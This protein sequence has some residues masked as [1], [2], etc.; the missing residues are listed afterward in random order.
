ML[1]GVADSA[2]V[3][4]ESARSGGE[5]AGGVLGV[6]QLRIPRLMQGGG[7]VFGAFGEHG[8]AAGGGL[9][10]P[11][12]RGAGGVA[13][14]LERG[15]DLLAVRLPGGLCLDVLEP[16]LQ[17]LEL[18]VRGELVGPRAAQV[19]E[20]LRQGSWRT[21]A[22]RRAGGRLAGGGRSEVGPVPAERG[23]PLRPRIIKVDGDK[24]RDVKHAAAGHRHVADG[25]G[26]RLGQ[27]QMRLEGG[28][29]LRAV[30]GDRVAEL[31]LSADVVGGQLP[32]AT[33]GA[34]NGQPTVAMHPGDGP[35]LPVRDAEAVVV[36][37]GHDHIPGAEPLPVAG[38][39]NAAVIHRADGDQP[40]PD[41]RVERGGVFTGVHHHDRGA[42]AVEPGCHEVIGERVAPLHLAAMDR[43]VATG[44][45]HVEH[46]AGIVA[47]P[48]R[49]GEWA[50]SLS[51]TVW[52][53]TVCTNRCTP[54]RPIRA[55]GWTQR[56]ARSSTPPR[57]TA[58]S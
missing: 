52:P 42:A 44:V 12:K 40:V 32:P 51:G 58:G 6:D 25:A 17:V 9:V 15:Q 46:R 31:D 41:R 11:F 18:P 2:A 19:G 49:Q 37:A 45:Q 20:D 38:D 23:D 4:A 56:Y 16:L 48:H 57:P 39:S 33:P 28:V 27:H 34:V 53:P 55:S 36:A 29:A 22:G 13:R 26:G 5:G 43:D 10:G 35:H 47:R 3:D 14:G 24:M 8:G 21:V 50:Y 7:V 30:A 54:C 1:F